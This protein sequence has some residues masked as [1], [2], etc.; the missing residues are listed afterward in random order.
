M[1]V[2]FGLA[3]YDPKGPHSVNPARWY[4]VRAGENAVMDPVSKLNRPYPVL[5]AA[6]MM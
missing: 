3:T 1:N 5:R 2:L 6:Q 4:R